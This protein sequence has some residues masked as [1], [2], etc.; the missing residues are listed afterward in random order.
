M[1]IFTDEDFPEGFGYDGDPMRCTE[2]KEK[3]QW[4]VFDADCAYAEWLN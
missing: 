2:C 4:S 3:A 1:E